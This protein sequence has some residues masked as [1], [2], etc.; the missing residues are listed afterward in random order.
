MK[1]AGGG[2]FSFKGFEKVMNGD[3]EVRRETERDRENKKKLERES[4]SASSWGLNLNVEIRQPGLGRTK[5]S[6]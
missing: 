3:G 5:I 6:S 4:K 1:G 2:M